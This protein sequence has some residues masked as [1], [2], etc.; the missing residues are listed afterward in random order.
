MGDEFMTRQTAYLVSVG[1][2]R[3][4]L[5]PRRLSTAALA[6]RASLLLFIF[7]LFVP[8]AFAAQATTPTLDEPSRETPGRAAYVT[9]SPN[10]VPAGAGQGATMVRW[11]TGDGSPGEVRVA[12]AGEPEKLFARGAQGSQ[13]AGWIASGMRCEFRLYGG[14]NADILL[15]STEVTGNTETGG[16]LESASRAGQTI[17]PARI[18]SLLF[19]ALL[20]A[21]ACYASRKN[22]TRIAEILFTVFIVAAL[23]LAFL[24]VV[25][26]EPRPLAAQP[27]PD[28]QEYADAARHLAS[29]E[30]YATRVHDGVR[31]PPRY[32]PGFPLALAPFALFGE[33]PSNVQTGAKL[34]TL[35]YV[36]AAVFAAWRIGGRVAAALVAA[37]IGL[38]PFARVY[39]SLV[40]SD[41]FA[42][43]LTMLF[44]PLLFRPSKRS[45]S[46]AGALAG[47]LILVRL[48]MVINLAA[49][50]IALPTFALRRRLIIFAAPFIALFG[51]H[52]W[53][54]F[55]SPLRTGYDYWLPGMKNFDLTF[56][57]ANSPTYRDGPWIVH[58][59]LGALL[60]QWVCP[61][62]L[63][64]PQAMLPHLVFYPAILL[65]LFWIFAPP[66]VSIIGIIY[67]WKH[68]RETAAKFALWLIILNLIFY[69]FYFHQGARFI[70]APATALLIFT[71]VALSKI[72][73]V[74]AESGSVDKDSL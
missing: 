14:A 20:F 16:W 51:L 55:G 10:P 59:A 12:V 70:A 38:S 34:F 26:A 43:G 68:R 58:D 31:H 25:T 54:V 47:A 1:D 37:M 65:N 19:F 8:C 9:A 33:Y 28:A 18:A 66:L 42:A 53:A 69:M 17:N 2:K 63:G 11:S 61:C 57:V 50:L 24:V 21:A 5:P 13:E 64:G 3:D 29:G 35:L 41:A 39:A 73:R 6:G 36:F 71:A 30:G 45:V 46:I 4:C 7:A 22:K 15:A 23:A 56:I 62:S 44:I 40:L 52:N 48:P 27:F 49:L 72:G 67:I 74:K 60:W 32:P